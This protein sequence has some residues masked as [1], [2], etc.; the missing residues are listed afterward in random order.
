L[1]HLFF[2]MVGLTVSAIENATTWSKYTLTFHSNKTYENP[3]YDVK[4]FNA[5]FTSPS[6][7]RKTV[8]GF[9][10]GG[11]SWE[12]RFLPDETGTWIWTSVCSDKENKRLDGQSG[13]FLCIKPKDDAFAFAHG[14]VFH[15]K[16]QYHL[17]FND[18][19]P[20]FWTACTAWNGALK[21]TSED[22][23]YYL[24]QRK[25]NNYNGEGVTKM[26]KD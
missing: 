25:A 9:W 22:W 6:G 26:Q 15:P 1:P 12:I 24:G 19:T 5:T 23:G 11:I 17:S 8:N 21:S 3:V 16:G 18:G 13:T 10:N 7:I 14:G 2:I 4:V 20:F